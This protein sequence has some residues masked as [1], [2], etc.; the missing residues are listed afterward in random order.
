MAVEMSAEGVNVA[1]LDLWT[2]F[3]VMAGWVKGQ[4][5]PLPGSKE[6][7]ENAMLKLLLHDGMLLALC[8]IICQTELLNEVTGL[9]FSNVAYTIYFTEIMKT[10]HKTWP[11]QMPN[12]KNI[13]Y[14][15]G[16]LL[17]LGCQKVRL[18]S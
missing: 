4:R 18:T 16:C 17:V 15:C 10:I 14:V 8:C 1:L 13:P 3:M 5:E 7:A 6:V 9:H 12:D 2:V 11:D